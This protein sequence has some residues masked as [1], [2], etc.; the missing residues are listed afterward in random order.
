MI[1]NILILII[2]TETQNI[3]FEINMSIKYLY[4]ISIFV[5]N[6]VKNDNLLQ[7]FTK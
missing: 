2:V 1:V 3:Q 6:I 4:E 7:Y 5:E